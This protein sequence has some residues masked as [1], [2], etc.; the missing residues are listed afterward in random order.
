MRRTLVALAIGTV[1]LWAQK[2]AVADFGVVNMKPEVAKAV[3]EIASGSLAAEGY[4]LVKVDGISEEDRFTALMRA[5]EAG[6]EMLLTGSLTSV[7]GKI[8]LWCC[9][10]RT[11]GTVVFQDKLSLESEDEI[12]EGIQSMLIA[13]RSGKKAREVFEERRLSEKGI[14]SS[15]SSYVTTNLVMG[16]IIPMMGSMGGGGV[17]NGGSV[18]VNYETPNWAGHLNTGLYLN[19]SATLWPILGIRADYLP[20]GVSDIS[21]Y[22]GFGA[23]FGYFSLS[24][25]GSTFG[26]IL[27]PGI[28]L[29]FFRTYEVRLVVDARYLILL[30]AIENSNTGFP[31]GPS[32][33]IGFSYQSGGLF[34]F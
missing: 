19:D 13:S 2:V 22:A 6:A 24:E 8:V 32:F 23:G 15:K 4:E 5:E 7:D 26:W 12:P 3:T 11:D 21:P 14:T 27:D 18:S 30:S 33:S 29:M 25:E 16:S 1:A 28:G 31:N 9:F 10:L 34:G 20:T 17:L